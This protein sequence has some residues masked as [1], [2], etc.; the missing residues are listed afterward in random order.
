L[1]AFRRG[2]F[3]LSRSW[4]LPPGRYT[5]ETAVQD[6]T[7][8]RIG[9]SR[10][11]VLIQRAGDGPA[12]S[13]VSLIRRVDPVASGGNPAGAAVE[14]EAGGKET[15]NSGQAEADSSEP[16]DPFVC[17]VGKVAPTLADVIDPR[18]AGS[19]SH[20]FVIY[21]AS[22]SDAKPELFLQYLRDGEV[23]AQSKPELPEPRPDGSIPYIATAPA[24]SFPAG[25][26]LVNVMLKQGDVGVVERAFFQVSP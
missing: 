1:D 9:A 3:T 26:Y 8:G 18:T 7:S 16:I 2:T 13:S 4:K 25:Q 10:S 12:L 24:G 15:A 19:V 5:L 14:Q 11:V 22:R 6:H 20:Y 17:S 23:V 21:P